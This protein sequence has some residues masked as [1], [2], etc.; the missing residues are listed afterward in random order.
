LPTPARTLPSHSG[1]YFRA[2]GDAWAA[3]DRRERDAARARRA[4]ERA[5]LADWH[6]LRPYEANARARH[7]ESWRAYRSAA[8]ADP[9]AVVPLADDA[10]RYGRGPALRRCYW[11]GWSGAEFA[12]W[13]QTGAELA[14]ILEPPQ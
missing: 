1:H 8:G 9:A 3:A 11:F 2:L 14:A 5:E 13:R 4:D 6:A 12:R 7:L 10:A